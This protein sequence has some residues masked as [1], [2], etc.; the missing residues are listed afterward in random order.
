MG[1]KRSLMRG[2]TLKG[3]AQGKRG[4]WTTLGLLIVAS[5]ALLGMVAVYHRLPSLFTSVHL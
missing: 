1:M 4:L 2:K 3:E 5:F